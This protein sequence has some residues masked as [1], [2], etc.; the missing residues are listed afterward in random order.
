LFLCGKM[1]GKGVVW[2]WDG[3]PKKNGNRGGGGLDVKKGETLVGKSELLIF[4]LLGG[5]G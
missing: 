2:G 1:G 5:L 4:L 3:G